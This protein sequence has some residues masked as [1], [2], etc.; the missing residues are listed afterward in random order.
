MPEAIGIDF[1]WRPGVE[2]FPVK[3]TDTDL[4]AAAAKQVLLTE[5]GERRMRPL[6]GSRLRSFL[7]E[8][9]DRVTLGAIEA[10]AVLALERNLEDDI[11]VIDVTA[12][13]RDSQ[14]GSAVQ[15]RVI[16]LDIVF[17]RQG[18]RG[19]AVVELA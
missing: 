9:I 10:E 1:P 7:F 5:L 18:R 14:D 8:N 16:E 12:R 15:L 6:F 4:V 17:D 3:A 11:L 19:N 13:L 2:G